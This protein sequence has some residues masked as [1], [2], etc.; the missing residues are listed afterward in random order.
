MF[1]QFVVFVAY[2]SIIRATYHRW[3]G[4]IQS[5][6]HTCYCHGLTTPPEHSPVDCR[7]RRAAAASWRRVTLELMMVGSTMNLSS[8]GAGGGGGEQRAR[9]GETRSGAESEECRG[10]SSGGLV[11]SAAAAPEQWLGKFMQLC[12]IIIKQVSRG[13]AGKENGVRRARGEEPGRRA[14]SDECRGRAAAAAAMVASCS[15]RVGK[16]T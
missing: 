14:E 8:L 13:T 15:A 12:V 16:L 9:D 11:L 5:S 4:L 6:A 2:T 1:R 7:R 3:H 10:R